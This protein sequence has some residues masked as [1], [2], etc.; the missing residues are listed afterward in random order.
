MNR[1]L[2]NPPRLIITQ[3]DIDAP[4][5]TPR[6]FTWREALEYVDGVPG[7]LLTI[8]VLAMFVAGSYFALLI[9]EMRP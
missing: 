6:P 4:D 7:L 9:W 3:A 1:K 2:K 5:V 8:F